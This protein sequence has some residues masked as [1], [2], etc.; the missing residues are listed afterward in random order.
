MEEEKRVPKQPWEERPDGLAQHTNLA[1]KSS[2]PSELIREGNWPHL[3]VQQQQQGLAATFSGPGQGFGSHV[4]I[5]RTVSDSYSHQRRRNANF[6]ASR[7]KLES[8][9][10]SYDSDHDSH[11]LL[12][13]QP[14]QYPPSHHHHPQLLQNPHPLAHHNA[15]AAGLRVPPFMQVSKSHDDVSRTPSETLAAEFAEYVTLKKH[16]AQPPQHGKSLPPQVEF[17]EP[18]EHDLEAIIR[19]PS[20]NSKVEF[21][22]KLG[23]NENLLQRALVRLGQGAGQDQL[24]EELIRLQKSKPLDESDAASN[25]PHGGQKAAREAHADLKVPLEMTKSP[26]GKE[27]LPIVIDGSNVAMSHGNKNVFSC[28][29]IRICVA[30][31]Q[32]HGHKDITVFVPMWRKEASKPDTP[33]SGKVAV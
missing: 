22:L 4:P 27:L 7:N 14:Q 15:I 12:R 16:S 32:E 18:P 28:K 13:L 31:F 25:E 11:D 6:A 29:G 23:Y 24:L 33:I 17:Q 1:P 8:E 2:L 26:Q 21:A 3:M 30:W 20:Y 9:D 5:S 10:S 19:D